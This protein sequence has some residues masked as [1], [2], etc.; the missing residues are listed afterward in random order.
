MYIYTYEYMYIT[1]SANVCVRAE[2]VDRMPCHTTNNK[3]HNTFEQQDFRVPQYVDCVYCE[4][5][6]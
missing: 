2:G 3:T 6:V 5:Q 1:C 4:F